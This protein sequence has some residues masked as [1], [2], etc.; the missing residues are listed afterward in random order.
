MCNLLYK[1]LFCFLFL[2]FG[3]QNFA[4]SPTAAALDFNIFLEKNAKLSAH[5]AEG[6]IAIGKDLNIEGDYMVATK[7]AGSFQ[8]Q[9]VV[10]GLLING[11]ISYKSKNVLQLHNGYIKIGDIEKSTIWFK[12]KNGIAVPIQITTDDYN[13]KPRIQLQN[14]A[15]KLGVD[16][17]KNL[18]EEQGL[19]KFDKAMETMRE[20]SLEISK[21]RQNAKITDEK[22]DESNEKKYPS[23]LVITLEKGVNYLNIEGINLNKVSDLTFSSKPDADHVLVINIDADKTFS[24]DA[25]K[26]SGIGFNESAFVLYNFFNTT[27]LN[28]NGNNT[29]EGTLYAPFAD[30]NINGKSG[31]IDG[32][33]IGISLIH[34]NGEIHYSPFVSDLAKVGVCQAPVIGDIVGSSSV[35]VGL[36]AALTNT[37]LN[38]VWSS[39]NTNI[40]TVSAGIVT[41][42]SLGAANIIYTVTGICSTIIKSFPIA[43]LDCGSVSSGNTGGL[44]SISLG[45]AIT[46]RVYLLAQTSAQSGIN[47]QNLKSWEQAG[48]QKKSAGTINSIAIIDLVPRQLSNAK[49]KSF[50]TTPTDI[51]GMTNAKEVVSVDYTLNGNCK[52]VVFATTTKLA[53]YDHTKAVCDRLKGASVI[54]LEQRGILGMNVIRFALKYEDGHTE[55][56]I[57][58]SASSSS[59]RNT[60]G[61]QSNWLKA[62]YLPEDI[63][64]NFQIWSVSDELT[65]EI[66]KLIFEQLNQ[67]APIEHLKQGKIVPD[68]YFESAKRTGTNMTFQIRSSVAGTNGY[69]ELQEK[70]NEQSSVTIKK[71]PFSF[72]VPG[73]NTMQI[74]VADIFETTIKMVINNQIQDEVFLSDGSWAVDYNNSNTVLNKF[75]IKNSSKTFAS[76]EYQLFRN[77]QINAV[78]STYVTALKLLR[79]GGLPKD[80]TQFKSIKFNATCNCNLKI[81]LVKQSTKNWDDQYYIKIPLSTTAKDYMIDLSEFISAKSKNTIN[82]DD[83]NSVVFT[84]S[85]S[86]GITTN[87]FHTLINLAFSKETAAYVRS[88]SS[89]EVQVYPNPTS[90]RFNCSFQSDKAVHMQLTITEL[91]SG[92][93]VYS[94]LVSALKGSNLVPI[95]VASGITK[96]GTYLL[97]FHS[98]EG[99]YEPKKILIRPV[100]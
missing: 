64:Y 54:G 81:T 4:Q 51:L 3:E 56:I 6:P 98:E 43:I 29:I 65:V 22:G 99:G 74:A 69:F 20:K 18:I 17:T 60:F 68:T 13:S 88:L 36:T 94:K 53:I 45:D 91:T 80:L 58:F 14:S 32:Q 47:Y 25:W 31:I 89:K 72:G 97:S 92:I 8:V 78:T 19:I 82:A 33:I 62:D 10:V 9:K 34:E 90:G 26:Q 24:W 73:S 35:C 85:N 84:I 67:I 28:I 39:S 41:G 100:N 42:E 70:A 96:L 1:G 40:A 7:S 55:Y 52:A 23:Q 38:G 49:L 63:M 59:V 76:E 87:I 37:N 50:I 5:L 83:I 75:E 27:K 86:A 12:D 44:E 15:E 21:N 30:I 77:I 95:D 48:I 93:I 66:T 16:A 71:V 46:K 11:K 2:V 79:G 57:S 61:I